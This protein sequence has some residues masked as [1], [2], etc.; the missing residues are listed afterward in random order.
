[1]R[2]ISL[3]AR[4]TAGC[5]ALL[6]AMQGLASC[7]G[8]GG[9]TGFIGPVTTATTA[10]T[11]PAAPTAQDACAGISGMSIP[12]SMIGKP[13]SGA[14]VQSATFVAAD[15]KDNTN[16]EYCAVTGIIVPATAGAP[17]MEFQVNLPTQWNERA[18][19]MGGG[20]YDGTLVT[21]L[22]PYVSQPNGTP[23]ALKQGYVTLGGDGGHKGAVFDG[24]FALNDEALLN[25]G[26]L[27]VKKV[28]DVAMAI[29]QKRY[30]AKPRRFYFIGGSQG[31][32]EG[33]DAAARYA[34]DYDGV[35]ANYPA[36]NL[37][38]LQQA[39]LYVGR[40]LYDNGGA[41]WIND[42]KRK[43][44]VNAVY[45]AC[46]SLDGLSDGII[47]NIQACNAAFNINTVKATLRCP[48]GADAGDS[49]LS[50]AQINAIDKISSPYDLGFPIA[51]QQVFARW[52]L[53]EG[54]DFSFFGAG[55]ALGFAPVPTSAATPPADALLYTIGAAHARYFVAKDPLLNPLTYDPA[56]YKARLQE[57]GGITEVTQQS[58]EA[59]RAKGGK[60]ILTHG[61]T[62]GLI[63]PHNTEDYYNLQVTQ[64]GQP[65]VDSFIRFFMI[66]GF[67]H[68]SGRYNL[69]YDGLAVLSN[70]VENGQ[71]PDTIASVDNNAADPAA[72]RSRPMCRWPLWPRFTGAA[73]TE[74]NASSYTCTAS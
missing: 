19:H 30:G 40:A 27:S 62:D 48:G 57:L 56:N 70:W 43:L 72:A 20:G 45:A 55:S 53:L 71:A 42:N 68:G 17:T 31:G 8:G 39:S 37:S 13:T 41:G 25:Y 74:S 73:G 50:D 47:G 14:I 59:F 60:L 52:P 35:I 28:H 63:S 44:L 10:G 66:P 22:G 32:H 21:G 61:T 58:L 67:D 6:L 11:T 16:G 64:F 12:A 26:Q 34:A 54:G 23:N 36:Y 51:G 3:K 7:G 9:G 24:T 1:M 5:V 65:A 33:L 29:I 2:R 18:L 4:R 49:C 46:D 69:G 15:A 38:L